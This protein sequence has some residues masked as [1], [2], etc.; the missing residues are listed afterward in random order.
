[1]IIHFKKIGQGPALFIL[2][3]IFGSGD[4][5]LS[6]GR[7]LSEHFTVYLTDARNHGQSFHSDLF[8]YN[9]MVD[10]LLNVLNDE[11][12]DKIILIGHSMG[13]K[14]AMNFALQHPK[15]VKSLIVV[16]MAPKGY[17]PHHHHI[18]KA[19]HAIDLKQIQSRKDAENKL[20][21]LIQDDGIRQFI[22]KNLRRDR[23]GFSWKINI[24]AIESN[25][26]NIGVPVLKGRNAVPVLFIRGANSDY[27]LDEDI[28]MIKE[29]FPSATLSTIPDSGHWV[30]S[31]QPSQ[32]IGVIKDF[33]LQLVDQIDDPRE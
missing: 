13:G 6:I 22:L 3:G 1:M 15:K 12:L 26:E 2:H 31:E 9:A 18:F 7:R 16:D 25:I 8:D 28:N 19:F 33:L 29:Y 30:H 21:H 10:D 4:N 5:W 17:L 24:K 32:V 23:D 27:I 20:S 11:G 14:T